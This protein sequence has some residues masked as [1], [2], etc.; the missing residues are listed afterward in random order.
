MRKENTTD[1][2]QEETEEEQPNNPQPQPITTHTLE[3]AES[4]EPEEEDKQT[5]PNATEEDK[6]EALNRIIE[7]ILNN[8]KEIT[9]DE[10]M[11]R[12][13]LK[14]INNNGKAKDLIKQ[15]NEAVREITRNNLDEYRSATAINNL[16]YATALTIQ[17]ILIPETKPKKNKAREGDPPWKKRIQSRI[18]ILRKDLSVINECLKPNIS[19]T[20]KEKKEEL[21]AKY[22]IKNNKQRTAIT[23]KLKQQISAKTYRIKRYTK[24]SNQY[25]QNKQFTENTGKLYNEMFGKKKVMNG[26]PTESEI[27]QYW[28]NIWE[29]DIEHNSTADWIQKEYDKT[30][31]I[32]RMEWTD[33]NEAE[34][35]QA[36]D[37]T[38]NWKAAGIDGIPNFWWKKMEAVHEHLGKAYN[39]MIK[40]EQVTPAWLAKGKTYLIP[41]S[42]ET[43]K[44]KNYRPITCLNNM[45][46]ILTK[47]ISERLYAHLFENNLY[48]DEQKGC[49]KN[50]YGCKD[51]L[52]TSSMIQKDCKNNRKQ[53]A[54]AWIDYRKAFDS[55]P[56][57]WLVET[58]NIY[59]TSSVL[60]SF[61]TKTMTTWKTDL[62]L[63]TKSSTLTIRDI[64]IKKGIYQ[65][66]SLS[67]LLFCM[68]LFPLS[69]ILN[70]TNTGYTCRM[71]KQKISHLLYVDDLKLIAKSEEELAE[72]L[73]K[74]QEFSKDIHMQ[75]GL[76]KC[77]KAAFIKGR[78]KTKE[79]IELDESTS[80]KALEQHEVYKY[81][82][83]DENDG[84]QHKEMKTKLEKEYYRR[85]RGIL[86]SELNAKN[87]ISA[88]TALAVPVLQYSFGIIKWT[89]AELRKMDRQTRK[90][91]NIHG[92]LH[93][94]A[95]VDRLYLPRKEGG[96]GMQSLETSHAIAMRGLNTYIKLK[97]KDKY[98]SM[99]YRQR[100]KSKE[101]DSQEDDLEHICPNEPETKRVKIIKSQMKQEMKKEQTSRWKEKAMHGQIVK[102]VEKET[103]NTA[104]SWKW[105]SHANLKVETEALITACQEQAIATI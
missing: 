68:S 42:D 85:T 17:N 105:L 101:D 1:P 44:A 45:Y 5:K 28:R 102:E 88:I 63:S 99:V 39:E 12:T 19:K 62:H 35:K 65:G 43:D 70:D 98:I 40:D 33:I 81:L 24:R 25:Y 22:N 94:R 74:V 9:M 55:I 90:L 61:I 104:E 83:I 53:L 8:L 59:R 56:H 6:S 54:I 31:S 14:K 84:I 10:N 82:G 91:L 52:V 34:L 23:E 86:K 89:L 18:A 75:F 58:L 7:Q 50:S 37:G 100:E 48:P 3:E 27:Q 11:Q 26:T 97:Q 32:K 4:Q 66:D 71:E 36:I 2:E 30:A 77:A 69:S 38:A 93:P 47:I 79:N 51:H 96:R 80:I 20:T 21:Y 67:P 16:T 13:P 87:K 95:D 15:G 78:L 92:A 46:K 41:K 73:E 72:Q 64:T 49:V 76:D 57:S 103:I 60:L 29:D